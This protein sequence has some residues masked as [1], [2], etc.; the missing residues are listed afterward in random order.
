ME[1]NGVAK[2][3]QA[4]HASHDSTLSAGSSKAEEDATK[5]KDLEDEVKELAEKANAACMSI[6][7]VHKRDSSWRF[8]TLMGKD[9]KHSDSQTTK[10]RFVFSKPN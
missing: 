10:T 4:T 6:I 5:I 7:H 9:V 3:S 2:G 8:V 1:T